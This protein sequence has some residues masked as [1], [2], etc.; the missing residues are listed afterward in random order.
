MRTHIR[1]YLAFVV[2]SIVLIA[3]IITRLLS[4]ENPPAPEASD[5]PQPTETSPVTASRPACPA[6]DLGVELPCLGAATEGEASP[7]VLVNVWAWWCGPCREELPVIEEFAARH[8]EMT[9]VGVHADRDAGRGAA[10]LEDLG[11]DIPSF[12]DDRGAAAAAWSLP[13]VVPVTVVLRDGEVERIL[14]QPFDSVAA[15]EEAVR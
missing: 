13:G 12:Q 7:Y 8:P 9:V 11:V 15:L 2:V 14:P 4:G 5:S 3:F 10:L 1:L 6:A